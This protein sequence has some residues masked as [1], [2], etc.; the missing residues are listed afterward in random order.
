MI[1]VSD[2][3]RGC[4]YELN[5]AIPHRQIDVLT[6]VKGRMNLLRKWYSVTKTTR[7]YIKEENPDVIIAI[8]ARMFLFTYIAN[9]GLNYPIIVADHTSFNRKCGTL[10]DFV[11]NHLYAKAD[12]MSILT[13]K[14]FNLLGEK[15]PQKQVIYNP[16]SFDIITEK[17]Q[18][19]KIILCAG[20]LDDWNVKG[21]D[22]LIDIW[23]HLA[24][25]YS[26]WT[27]CIAGDGK[28]TS[29]ATI[30][31]FIKSKDLENRVKMLGHIDDMKELYMHTSIFALSSRV[32][33][34]PMVLMEAM[35]QGCACVAFEVYGASSEMMD[36]QSGIIIK[37]GDLN[38]FEKALRRLMDNDGVREEYQ[39]NAAKSVSQFSVDRFA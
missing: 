10:I 17:T 20:R 6:P 11:R 24:K 27:L 33:G 36:K 8:Q 38:S 25:Q 39:L 29:R 22:I 2:L 26:Q 35:S 28:E 37:D 9:I 12:G 30:D 1:L 34:F 18:R 7:R 21:F 31:N 32:E 19:E 23:S 3:A 16:L 15:Y 14:D 13:Q 4:K 5:P